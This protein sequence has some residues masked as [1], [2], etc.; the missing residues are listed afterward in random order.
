[1]RDEEVRGRERAVE[2]RPAG[3]AHRGIKERLGREL[4]VG[5]LQPGAG[6]VDAAAAGVG[7]NFG[8]GHWRLRRVQDTT[9]REGERRGLLLGEHGADGGKNRRSS[10]IVGV[11]GLD[12]RAIGDF[13][14]REQEDGA[15][16]VRAEP[17]VAARLEQA[18]GGAVLGVEQVFD[19]PRE[20]ARGVGAEVEKGVEVV[21]PGFRWRGGGAAKR[22]PVLDAVK[23]LRIVG[24]TVGV[25]AVFRPPAPRVVEAGARRKRAQVED[26]AI[27]HVRVALVMVHKVAGVRLVLAER[28]VL[29]AVLLRAQQEAELRRGQALVEALVCNETHQKHAAVLL[30][31]LAAQ[32]V[33]DDETRGPGGLPRQDFLDKAGRRGALVGVARE[34]LERVHGVGQVVANRAVDRGRERR[35]RVA[36]HAEAL[37]RGQVRHVGVVGAEV[38][39]G[40][41]GE[42]VAIRQER[43]AELVVG[44]AGSHDRRENVGIVLVWARDGAAIGQE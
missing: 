3:H 13:G 32:A 2:H 36:V 14:A 29:G 27:E 44:T 18:G 1:M 8:H 16:L 12:R 34:N 19:T 38:H 9:G 7:G 30:V 17:R 28:N 24:R 23:V 35:G 40:Q 41:V 39:K 20:L 25:V 4:R 15:V 10:D 43:C 42:V 6:R 37:G 22:P 26:N 21:R 11:H 31:H 33:V 5:A